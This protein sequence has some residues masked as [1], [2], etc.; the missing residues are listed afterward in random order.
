MPRSDG[1]TQAQFLK[2]AIA[3]ERE[4]TIIGRRMLAA[5][6]DP[7]GADEV[8]KVEVEFGLL[9][10]ESMTD[11]FTYLDSTL[12]AIRHSVESVAEAVDRLDPVA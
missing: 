1:K 12:T 2:D 4:G 11:L 5:D 10:V 9:D 7:R 8:V 6:Q 3:K